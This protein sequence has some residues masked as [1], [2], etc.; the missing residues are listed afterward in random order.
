MTPARP[1][2]SQGRPVSHEGLPASHGDTSRGWGGDAPWGNWVAPTHAL[3]GAVGLFLVWE[4]GGGNRWVFY[5]CDLCR[6]IPG[7]GR[8]QII[9]S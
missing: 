8:C 9:E 1:A 7:S 3:V 2:C 5:S 4:G 6:D